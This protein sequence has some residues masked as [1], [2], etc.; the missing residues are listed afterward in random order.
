EVSEKL[1]VEVSPGEILTTIG[2]DG[3]EK[4][5]SLAWVNLIEGWKI[6]EAYPCA[7]S[8]AFE[9]KFG[10]EDLIENQAPEN[11]L[12]GTTGWKDIDSISTRGFIEI[13]EALDLD[14]DSASNKLAYAFREIESDEDRE[15]VLSFGSDDWAQVWINGKVVQSRTPAR[16]AYLDQNRFSAHLNKGNNT[17][18]VKI[19]NAGGD[20]K[21]CMGEISRAQEPRM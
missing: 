6:S 1:G 9:N 20:W 10:P 11:I 17:I 12:N 3:R 14:D 7:N 19:G 2:V 5:E 13:D 15:V 4:E 16:A 18:L 21:F 8:A